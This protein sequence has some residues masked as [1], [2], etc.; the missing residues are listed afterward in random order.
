VKDG[1]FN[2]LSFDMKGSIFIDFNWSYEKIYIKRC[3]F[4]FF[5]W[6]SIIL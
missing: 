4:I 3:Y 5:K 1:D 2:G 6:I